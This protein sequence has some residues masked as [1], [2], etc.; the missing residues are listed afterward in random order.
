M[1]E[2]SRLR[3]VVLQ[4]LV[5]SLLA[6]LVGRLYFLQVA[7]NAEFTQ[8]ATSNRVR[9]LVTTPVRGLIL[10]ARG[11]QL[12]RNRTA[13]VVS[14]SRTELMHQ[15][16]GGKALV[17]RV[18][19]V[20]G[21]PFAEVWGRTRICGSDKDAPKP[22]LCWNGSPLQPIPVTDDVNLSVARQNAMAQQILEM[23]E[24][25]PGV[26][27]EA[28]AVREYPGA[29]VGLNAA[30]LLGYLGP[31]S[32]AELDAQAASQSS[33]GAEVVS[34][35][36][37]SDLVGRAGLEKQYDSYLR[38]TPGL[39]RLAVDSVGGITSTVDAKA[40]VPGSYLV[41][42]IDADVQKT[43]EDALLRAITNARTTGDPNKKGKK[44]KADSGAVV[45]L[46]V[47]TG[48][49]VA[50]ASYPMYD[51][52]LWVDGRITAKDYA[53]ITGAVNNY[54]NLSRATQV[55]SAPG[56]TF[57]AVTTPA[58]VKAGYSVNGSYPCP[59]S[60]P[61]GGTAKGNYESESFGTISLL[62]AIQVSCDTVF[63]KFAAETWY[64]LGGFDQKSDAK[65][66]FVQMARAYGL[67]K[68]TGVDLPSE[69]SGRIPGREWKRDYWNTTKA[70]AC[71]R[72][73]KGY[74][75]LLSQPVR[76]AYLLKLAKENCTDGWR[77]GPG[78]AANFAIGQGDVLVTPLQ[79][80]RV[81]A[82]VANGGTLVTPH[83]AQAVV[84]PDGHVVKRFA[85][86]AAGTL[87]AS[88]STIA[89]L[90]KA[91]RSVTEVGTGHGPF[92]RPTPFP[93]DKLPVATK[94]GTAEVYGKQSTS[95]FASYA[96]AT[97]PQY[98]VVMTVSQGGTGSGISGPQVR[99][100][101][102]KLFGVSGSTVDLSKA[103][104]VGGHP[105]TR[106]PLVPGSRAA[107]AAQT[108]QRGAAPARVPT[109]RTPQAPRTSAGDVPTQP[110]RPPKRR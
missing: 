21:K 73:Q 81:Y 85:P 28:Q 19:A 37:G 23:R 34:Q 16:D 54:P 70:V 108:R 38:G 8:A 102:E 29:G 46:D 76:A 72:A 96:P 32:Q 64:R 44:F 12:A 94:T 92:A 86:R 1:N 20:I 59:A 2:R 66:P 82:A 68:P 65:D 105:A 56:S 10:D 89:F 27:A 39:R 22:P 33:D 103:T 11:R 30:Q 40:A 110:P 107:L 75:E 80:A 53:A 5:A 58:A 104:P 90:Q 78:D 7:S 88:P 47:R 42:T 43:A 9:E 101:Y 93:L 45:V 49:I 4:V 97:H 3:L 52:N 41:T 74:P 17:A 69:A 15:K 83:L 51:P 71:V 84:R 62:R 87:P 18:A 14:I 36:A 57:K 77:Y 24:E 25:F 50:M 31:V 26:T 63:Y 67:G 35:L 48:G 6:T 79:M 13:L 98:A 61:I 100:I 60:Y 55:E 99:T 109:R 106:L 95:W 91:L